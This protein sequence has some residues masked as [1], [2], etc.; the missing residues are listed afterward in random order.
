[1]AKVGLAKVGLSWRR[2]GVP[3]RGGE[4][5]GGEGV[6]RRGGRGSA[7]ISDAPTKILIS[8][9]RHTT[10]QHTPPH[11]ATQ[12]QR[13]TTQ[14]NGGPRTGSRGRGSCREELGGAGR[15]M[16][17]K[18]RHEQQIPKSS[19]IG[20]DFFGSS[21]GTKRPDQKKWSGPKAVRAKSGLVKK[22]HGPKGGTGQKWSLS[23]S[24]QWTIPRYQS[25]C[26]FPTCPRSWRNAEPFNRNAEPQRRAAKHLGHTWYVGKRF[27]KSRCVFFSTLSA[28]IESM[29]FLN[30]RA[31]SLIHSGKE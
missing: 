6:W 30:R 29:E 8:Q 17:Q 14:H 21:L 1:M 19:P 10:P 9:Y 20:Q 3:R 7:Q 27:C 4:G 28:G 22:W 18:R 24:T 26:V 31:A 13:H 23:I 25:T 5:R 12:Q 2:G 15:S 11:N 16:A